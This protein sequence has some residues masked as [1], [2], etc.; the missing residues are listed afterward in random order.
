MAIVTGQSWVEV[1][2]DSLEE[3]SID[4]YEDEYYEDYYYED[5]DNY[6]EDEQPW[7]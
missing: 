1:V 7:P 4:Y 6:Y 2:R 3:A 5:E